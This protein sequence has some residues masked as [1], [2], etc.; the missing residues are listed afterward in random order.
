MAAAAQVDHKAP[1][2]GEKRK[3]VGTEDD[4]VKRRR[5]EHSDRREVRKHAAIV[6]ETGQPVAHDNFGSMSCDM[7][8]AVVAIPKSKASDVK[9]DVLINRHWPNR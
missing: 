7:A 8:R 3:A 1:N 9:L 4:A 6:L 2:V 5:V